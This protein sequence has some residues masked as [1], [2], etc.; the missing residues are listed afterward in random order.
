MPFNFRPPAPKDPKTKKS[1]ILLAMPNMN[2][3]DK[4]VKF[5]TP[6]TIIALTTI[7]K[8][9]GYDFE[10]IDGTVEDISPEEFE[11]RI[12]K[13][14]PKIFLVSSIS[15]QYAA[16][17]HLALKLAKKAAPNCITV[18][19]GIYAT[20][21]TEGAIRN[22][23]TDFVFTGPAENRLPQVLE[24]LLAG[25]YEDLISKVDGIGFR[26]KKGKQVITSHPSFGKINK[27]QG[28]EPDYSKVDMKK[29]I[30]Q[31][32]QVVEHQSNFLEPTMVIQTSLGCVHQCTFCAVQTITGRKMMFRS[33]ENVLDEIGWF[34]K[35]YGIN[36]FGIIDELLLVNKKRCMSLFQ[37]IIDRKYDIKWKLNDASVWHMHEDLLELM[38]KS[39][40]TKIGM[41]AES[42]NQ[43][44]L[45]EVMKKPVKLD[46][47]KN[48]VKKCKELGMDIT[49]NFII[50]MPDETWEEIL[51]TI[52]FAERMD[53]DLVTFNVAQPFAGTPMAQT[54][55]DKG[56]IPQDFDW[57]DEKQYGNSTGFISTPEFTPEDLMNLR[58]YAWDYINFKNKDKTIRAARCLNVPLNEIDEHRH[59]NRDRKGVHTVKQK[60][61]LNRSKDKAFL[62]RNQQYKQISEKDLNDINIIRQ[63]FINSR[64]K[65][66][67]FEQA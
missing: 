35:E 13:I 54:C 19:G 24:F 62:I 36:H 2:W 1:D 63:K 51:E 66:P 3:F 12:K 32:A 37:G 55:K 27:H 47:I 57:T 41:S 58:T 64:K 56:Y 21:Y 7:M 50:G 40:C 25:K 45:D 4:R 33:V 5:M 65:I 48:V 10:F 9:A 43:R 46:V 59:Q 53:F 67:N 14:N 60:F 39:G 44:V 42:G 18:H 30:F 20:T 16:Q 17:T 6:F 34:M 11:K 49:S 8:N 23:D 31:E 61:S 28:T 29:Y 26:D 38:K 22:L 15:T 52:D